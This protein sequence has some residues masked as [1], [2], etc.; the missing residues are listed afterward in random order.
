MTIMH[1][2][3][4]NAFKEAGV[5]EEQAQKAAIA[6]AGDQGV[7]IE[8]LNKMEASFSKLE[9][10]IIEHIYLLDKKFLAIATIMAT[11]LP[12]IW[13]MLKSN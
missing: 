7:I 4:Y 1:A 13:Y 10:D 2:E 8:K 12:L 3:T 11:A 6:I 9:K 5:P